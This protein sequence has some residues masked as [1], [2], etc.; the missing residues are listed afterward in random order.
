MNYLVQYGKYHT[1]KLVE[2]SSKQDAILRVFDGLVWGDDYNH[3]ILVVELP[4]GQLFTI[5]KK[6]KV[7][8][9]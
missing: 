8:F 1:T 9:K 3:D 4:K 2:A 5:D 6:L 7:K